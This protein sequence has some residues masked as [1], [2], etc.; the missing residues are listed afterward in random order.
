MLPLIVTGDSGPSAP[1]RLLSE[2]DHF[3]ML[4]NWPKAA[5]RY[6]QAESLYIRTGDKRNALLA[7]LG[8][9]WATAVAG[10][11]PAVV[12]EV[13]GYLKDSV[14]RNDPQLLL[15]A[16][17]TKAVLDRNANEMTSRGSWEEI[18]ALANRTQDEGWEARAKAEIGQILYMEGDIKSAADMVRDAIMS[19]LFHGDFGAAVN[20]TAMAG[21][22]FNEAGQPEAGLQ[23]SNT[24]IRLISVVPDGGFPYLAYQGKASALFA[25]NRAEEA[26]S[27]LVEAITRAREERNQLALA[28]LLVV[29]GKG[30]A[31]WDSAQAVAKLSEA[32]AISEAA[33]SHHIY[34]WSV[35]ELG[36]VLRD[37]GDLD[38]AE[39]ALSKAIGLLRNLED[40]YHLPGD[41]AVYADVLARKGNI[42]RADQAYS[43]VTDLID[44]LLVNVTRRQLKSSLI[45]TLSEAYVG[46]FELA[47]TK[48][49]DPVKAYRIIEEARGR[50]LADTLR[51]EYET[52]TASDDITAKSQQEISRIQ[53]QLLHVTDRAGR[54]NLLDQL[55]VAEQLLSPVRQTTLA[56]KSSGGRPQPAPLRELQSSLR[57]DEI[58][59]EYVLGER[60]SYCLR[61]SRDDMRLVTLPAGRK[62]IE[63]LVD[64]YL[65]AVRSRQS[66]TDISKELFAQILQP[67]LGAESKARLVVIPDGK[68]HQLPFDALRDS[69]GHYVLESHVVTY[70]PSATV[71][72]LLR[73]S[74]SSDQQLMNLV[75]VGGAVYSGTVTGRTPSENAAAS[76]F[77][78]D[79][80]TFPNLPGSKQEILTI[81]KIVGGTTKLLLEA[82]ATESSFKSLP[83]ENFRIAHLAV[84]GIANAQFPDR[85]ALVLG[86][87]ASGGDD[88]LLQVREIRDLP[89]RA[90]LV[91]LSACETGSGKLLGAEGIASLERAFLLAGAKAVVASLWTAD[92]IYTVALMKRFYQHLADGSD[93]GLAL[94]QAKLDLLQQ[95]GEQAL[96]IYWAGFTLVGEG[97]TPIFVNSR[98]TSDAAR[99]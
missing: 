23:Y 87:S 27:V 59:L 29:A 40:R 16:L 57:S 13:D 11:S 84:H 5:S 99:Q 49:R 63:S 12:E 88:G 91:V 36:R 43:E 95:F 58:V 68:L 79:A 76:F 73:Q 20:Y 42:E 89:L 69:Q 71:L 50:S 6:A 32:A 21:G 77:D 17:I 66:E 45:A 10:V 75:A 61:I 33:G 67:V 30:L 2:A 98:P 31:S 82:D 78:L 28:Q 7:R 65:A 53:T 18:L 26:E 41:L 8:F 1:Q 44:A 80:V 62:R 81:N 48:L 93:K 51:G 37:T 92:D 14:V 90:D 56:L 35:Y 86:S 54:Q 85:A 83:L 22:G 3:A 72:Y 47:V 97:S 19:Q 25:L 38:G 24:A 64:S 39:A 15:R 52:L 34:V 96:P 55:F 9:F 94:H 46:H 4:N 60:Q 74:R 70:A